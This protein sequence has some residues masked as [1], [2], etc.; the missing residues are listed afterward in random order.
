MREQD[1]SEQVAAANARALSTLSRAITLSQGQFALILVRCNYEVCKEQ[2]WS[3][4]QKLTQ[5]PPSKLVLSESIKTPYSIILTA[6]SIKQTSALVV[7]GL[8]SLTAIDQTLIVTNQVRDEFRRILTFPLVLWVT[9][10]VLQKMARFAP[11][12]KSWAATSIKFELSTKQL[13][14]LWHQTEDEIFATILNRNIGEFLPNE[15]LQLSPNCRRRQE[16][17]SALRDLHYPDVRVEPALVATWQFILGRDALSNDQIDLALEQYQQSLKFWQQGLGETGD[18]KQLA[19]STPPLPEQSASPITPISYGE[20]VGLVLYHISLCDARRAQLQ[21]LN[22]SKQWEQARKSLQASIEAFSAAQRLDWVAQLNIQLGEVLKNLQNWRELQA[23]ALESLD[24]PQIHNSPVLL[25]QAYGFLATV[26]QALSHWED[27]RELAKAALHQL[28]DYP[29]PQPRHQ[30]LFLLISAKVQRQ[31][32]ESPA[33]IRDL[34]QAIEIEKA[35][36]NSLKQYPQLYIDIL[37]ELRSLYLEQQQY[38]QAFELKQERRSVE[39][40][41]GFS[42]FLGAV[43]LQSQW[44]RRVRRNATSNINQAPSPLQIAAAGR[45]PDVHRLIERLSR[46]D[47]KLTVIHGSSG[48]GKSSLINAG[49]LPALEGQIIGAR[50]AIPVVQTVYKNWVGELAR[51]LTESF[52]RQQIES[53]ENSQQPSQTLSLSITSTKDFTKK[54]QGKFF[55]KSQAQLQEILRQLQL[56]NERNLLTVLVFDQFEEFFFVAQN[57]VERRQFYDFLSSC[58][59]LPFVKIILSLREDYLHYLLELE[60]YSNLNAINNNILDRELRYPLG[61][62]APEDAKNVICTLAT[63]SQFQL[64]TSLIKRLVHDLAGSSG[65]V[66]LIDLQVVGAQLQ[67]EKIT[68][69]KQYNALGSNPKASLVERSLL[70]LISDCGQEN[71]DILWQVLFSLT[72]E[73]GTRPLK[74][75]AELLSSI[76][77]VSFAAPRHQVNFSVKQEKKSKWWELGKWNKVQENNQEKLNLIVRILVGSGLVFRVFS[78]PARY[79]LVHDYLVEPI[80]LKVKQRDQLKIVAQLERHANELLRVRKK[81]LFSSAIGVAMALLAFTSAGLGWRAEVLRKQADGLW[82]NAHLSA[83]S[84]S[85]E[86]LFVSN[87]KFDALIEGLRAARF[88]KQAQAGESTAAQLK[89]DIRL[90]VVAVL[91]QAV[92]GASELNR[93]EGHSDIVS[94]VAFSPDG[95]L[96][97]SASRDETVKLWR[98]NG[99]LVTTLRGHK[100]SVTNVAFSPLD[101]QLIASASWD[102]TIKIWR[103]DGTVVQTL[104]GH[105][106]H[107]YGVSFSPNGQ[108]I[109]SASGD[110]TIKLWTVKGKLIRTLH[111]HDGVVKAVSFS[112][113]GQLIA[114]AGEDKM[115]RL[116]SLDG[117]LL[118]T[119]KGHT[120]EINCV[121][122]SPNGQ[123]IASASDD[124]TVKLWN[125]AGELI[126]TFPKQ[127]KWVF[128]VAFSADGQLIA[129]GS[130][131]STVRLWQLNGTLLKSFKG[132]SDSITAVS[133]NPKVSDQEGLGVDSGED[134]L[135]E[136][137]SQFQL[138]LLASA[139]HDKTI[140]LWAVSNQSRLILRGHQDNVRDVTFSPDG[141]LIASA[142]NDRT[143]KI[144]NRRGK[145]LKTLEGHTDRIFSVSFSPDGQLIASA[146]RDG[147]VKIWDRRGSLLKTLK[148]HKDW[149]LDVTFSPDSQLIASASRDGTVKI[150]SRRGMLLKTLRGHHERVNAVKFSPDGQLLA[151]A[152]DDKTLKL[153]TPNGKLLKT[154]T[155]HSNWVLDVSFSPDSQQLVSASYDNTVMLWSRKGKLLSI[156]EGHTDSVAKARFSPDG[157]VLATTSWDNKIQMWRLDDTMIKTLEGHKERVTSVSWSH[158]GKVLA[159][160]SQDD[161]V[162]VWNLDLDDLLPKSCNWLQDYLQNNPKVRKSDR[163]LCQLSNKKPQKLKTE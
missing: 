61:D 33:A 41:Y 83:L 141:Q 77:S 92:Y 143:V 64:E 6:Q 19:Y 127:G 94:H 66:R 21:Q 69:I 112:P 58:L 130:A 115:V 157:K 101:G 68:T 54:Q 70:N 5:A 120:G 140:K 34:E 98:P 36:P 71:E 91:S 75:K 80:R 142:S 85:S 50:V 89:S 116:W 48:V 62:L 119:L 123:L 40:Q 3:Q 60:R 124:Q 102:G 59:D 55:F 47:H 134:S 138:P 121:T 109:A 117:K 135:P 106:G 87:K 147:T 17:A 30:G 4:L 7:F 10:E 149:V 145:L 2:M 137:N 139:S 84:A 160:A 161:T 86:A 23:L 111:P 8:D 38:L 132:H 95:Q 163:Q 82:I 107:V 53:L 78:Q 26:A 15:A 57:L 146:S 88:L 144:W 31:L 152:S 99:T 153:W 118:Q 90:Q 42:P 104:R 13:L 29:S 11:D 16:L 32:G 122:F 24:K 105:T 100:G 110:G 150:W 73:K 158:D 125:K 129:S 113:N 43:P 103:P 56:A 72:D 37:E 18:R 22:N 156:L 93:L 28:D 97:A 52:A 49:L 51:L 67:A 27:A 81:Q 162:I 9:D 39:Q 148:E 159:S 25:A 46:N 136:P 131:D 114:S 74:T 65:A 133:F 35:L 126:R 151:S 45:Q 20:R 128:G 96:I 108:L 79:Q 44:W 1:P 12:F 76:A 155:G 14:S 63:A 154:L